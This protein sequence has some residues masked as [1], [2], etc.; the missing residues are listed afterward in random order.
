[1]ADLPALVARWQ[2]RL[3]DVPVLTGDDL[4]RRLERFRFADDAAYFAFLVERA[5]RRGTGQ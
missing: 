5:N 3:G 1:M 2:G 4:R